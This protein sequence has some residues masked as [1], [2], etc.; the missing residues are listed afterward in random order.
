[1]VATRTSALHVVTFAGLASGS[2]WS[3][4]S[5]NLAGGWMPYTGTPHYG[6]Y[7]AGKAFISCE[8]MFR[9]LIKTY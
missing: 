5:E 1:M 2:S 3:V 9:K 6:T 4:T 8:K 7:T